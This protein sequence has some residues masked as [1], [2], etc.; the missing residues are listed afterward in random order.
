MQKIKLDIR[1]IIRIDQ[2][3]YNEM[4]GSP[5]MLATKLS[6]SERSVYNY[7]SFMKQ[8]L[9]A[10]IVYDYHKISYVYFEE[11]DFKYHKR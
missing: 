11:W 3:I 1:L 8:E 7:I 9:N 6:I 10:P 5:K 4:T 2:L